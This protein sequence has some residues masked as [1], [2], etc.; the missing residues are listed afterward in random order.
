MSMQSHD[1]YDKAI[2]KQLTRIAASLERIEKRSV[3]VIH[4]NN[5][6]DTTSPMDI[7]K[8]EEE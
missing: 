8:H 6:L 3:F 4:T 2:L 7:N 5:D 1:N